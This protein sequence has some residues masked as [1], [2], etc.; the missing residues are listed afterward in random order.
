MGDQDHWPSPKPI[1][2]TKPDLKKSQYLLVELQE[3]KAERRFWKRK[4]M[5]GTEGRRHLKIKTNPKLKN[6]GYRWAQFVAPAP[7]MYDP[8]GAR[9]YNFG[10][11][12]PP[13]PPPSGG[14]PGYGRS[15]SYGSYDGYGY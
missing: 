12:R 3:E 5:K 15:G 13:P 14:F 9:A 6:K 8:I 11:Q 10:P 2:T 7:A 1:P 4:L